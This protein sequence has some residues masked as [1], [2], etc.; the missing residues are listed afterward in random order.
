MKRLCVVTGMLMLASLLPKAASAGPITVVDPIIGVRGGMFGSHDPRE[1][2][3]GFGDACP[4][5]AQIGVGFSCLIFSISEFAPDGITSLLVQIMDGNGNTALDFQTDDGE[6]CGFEDF[7][8]HGSDFFCDT[9]GLPA[10]QV[11]LSGD[12]LLCGDAGPCVDAL[13]YIKP[14]PGSNEVGGF[15]AQA[16]EING[17]AVNPVPEPGSLLLMGTG[18]ATLAG[19]RLRRKTS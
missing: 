1:G 16:L 19:R 3:L 11:R 6:S 7:G 18:I 14:L 5:D 2:T 9:A 17:T 12:A 8:C 4:E 15:T 10:G 13:L